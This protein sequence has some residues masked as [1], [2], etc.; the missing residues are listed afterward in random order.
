MN[1]TTEVNE[2]QP[3]GS[4]VGTFNAVDPDN[5]IAFYT[6]EPKNSYF[7][8]NNITGELNIFWI[9]IFTQ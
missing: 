4:V 8:I 5:K 7:V 3:I 9:I 6:I 1:Y 2:E